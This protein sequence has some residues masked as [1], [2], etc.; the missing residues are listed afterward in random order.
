M[1]I[2]KIIGRFG[3]PLEIQ[4][5]RGTFFVTKKISKEFVASALFVTFAQLRIIHNQMA[6]W[7]T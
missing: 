3:A 1:L 2:D 4:S 5:D 7:N 6:L